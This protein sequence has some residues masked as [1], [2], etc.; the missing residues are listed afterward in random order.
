[1]HEWVGSVFVRFWRTPLLLGVKSGFRKLLSK[2]TLE[3]AWL[4]VMPGAS[5]VEVV[6][7]LHEVAACLLAV[8]LNVCAQSCRPQKLGVAIPTDE[9]SFSVMLLFMVKQLVEGSEGVVA[10]SEVALE[11]LLAIVNSHM[12][13]QVA[14]FS[15][16]F[17]TVVFWTHEWPLS[18]MK[19]HVDLKSSCSRVAFVASRYLADKRFFT[20][21]SEFVSLEMALCYEFLT[22]LRTHKRPFSS[23]RTHVSL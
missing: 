18:C 3:A 7:S 21:M 5:V 9:W 23:M 16:C 6:L 12:S 20:G 11:R 2:R 1:V 19:T 10:I 13:Q 22:A 4:L 14:L 17:L 8:I 15:E